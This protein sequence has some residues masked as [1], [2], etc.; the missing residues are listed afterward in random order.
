[1]NGMETVNTAACTSE[2]ASLPPGGAA[3]LRWT[4]DQ[5]IVGCRSRE[6]IDPVRGISRGP[7]VYVLPTALHQ[8]SPRWTWRGQDLDVDRHIKAERVSG[9]IVLKNRQVLLE[10]YGLGR[11]AKDRWTSYSVG[12]SVTS[13]LIGAAIQDGYI[14][15][16]D[17]P[18]IDYIHE[19]KG[20]AY[21][22]VT[23]RQL[24]TMTSGVK[25]SEDYTDPNSDDALL[26]T[27]PFIDGVNPGVAYMRRLPRI[28]RP[29]AKFDYK[30]GDSHLAGVLVSKAA[31]KSMSEYLS[32]KLWR[33]F[34]M[35]QDAFWVVDPAGQEYGGGGFITTLRDY[36]RIGQFML[37]G[38][39]AGAIQVL[40]P[41]WLAEATRAHLTFSPTS[42]GAT[43][44]GYH[45]WIYKDA[46]AA[47]GH[48]GQAIF[49]YPKD[50]IVIAINSAWPEPN[51][52]EYGQAQ[53]A[54]VEALHAAAVAQPEGP[55]RNAW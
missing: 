40:S 13:I 8:I 23:V 39:R 28:H 25:W 14:N 45:W 27:A 52:P 9:V 42:T 46:Y 33:P 32:D 19:L 7:H 41:G 31:G 16:M 37:D 29:G 17:A 4:R 47:L 51:L 50:K 55:A 38:G 26:M 22:G 11:T 15:G 35:E 49:V 36:A 5:Q 21:D 24:L 20:S 43:G 30:T 3:M 18:L 10:R 44:Y 48:A 1:M 53:A 34:G 12:K 6:K 2:D 54:F